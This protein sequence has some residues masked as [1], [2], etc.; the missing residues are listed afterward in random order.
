[1]KWLLKLFVKD[2][3]NIK[4]L[5]VR[6]SYGKLGANAGII[7]NAILIA[8][9]LVA[10]ILANSIAIIGD[11]LNSSADIASSIVTLIGFK[12]ASK[13]ADKDHPFGHQRAEYVA[14]FI[15]ALVVGVVG[16]EVAI[17]SV[18]K[19]INPEVVSFSI[20][21]IVLLVISILIKIWQGGF[22][23]FLGK[24]IDSLSLLASGTDAYNDVISTSCVLVGAIVALIANINIDGY[25]GIVAAIFILISAFGLIKDAIGPL[26]GEAPDIKIIRDIVKEVKKEKDVLGIHDIVVHQYGPNKVFASLH[27][28]VDAYKNVLESHDMIDNIEQ[29]VKKKFDVELVI[30][31]DPIDTK[32]EETN[33]LRKKVGE[34]V[35]SIGNGLSYHDFRMVKGYTHSNLIFDIVVPFDCKY[36]E[37]EIKAMIRKEIKKIDEKYE[38]VINFDKDYISGGKQ[39]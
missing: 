13:P 2:Y 11:A 21:T 9:K 28:E 17:S 15:V 1:M 8:A 30:H 31:M 16:V 35:A 25:L 20:L 34:I 24:K 7:S 33:M 26:I 5:Q 4:N 39:K 3:E 18:Q 36:D 29:K 10:G 37:K 23:K 6:T 38:I 32:D 12:V 22:Y 14:G 19:I 27:C